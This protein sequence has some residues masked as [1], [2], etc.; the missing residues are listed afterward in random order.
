[1]DPS[2]TSARSAMTRCEAPA[3]PTSPMTSRVVSMMRS[4]RAGSCLRSC[5]LACWFSATI[6]A[7]RRWVA[8]IDPD[9]ALDDAA[10]MPRVFRMAVSADGRIY[11]W[12]FLVHDTTAAAPPR[13]VAFSRFT[14]LDDAGEAALAAEAFRWLQRTAMDERTSMK[15]LAERILAADVPPVPGPA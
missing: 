10:G 13:Y 9:G 6:V 14:D 2:G 11:L 4:R 7:V 3:T 12:G 8:G 15:A 1:M 5:C